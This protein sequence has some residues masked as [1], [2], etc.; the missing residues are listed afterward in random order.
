MRYRIRPATWAGLSGWADNSEN[1]WRD[2]ILWF[3]STLPS[4][5]T[6]VTTVNVPA[7]EE[8]EERLRLMLPELQGKQLLISASTQLVL[9]RMI[10]KN[11]QRLDLLWEQS[12][13]MPDEYGNPLRST[14]AD[15]RSTQYSLGS[16]L[17]GLNQAALDAGVPPSDLQNWVVAEYQSRTAI[18]ALPWTEIGIAVG[19]AIVA[20]V[21]IQ[22]FNKAQ[23]ISAVTLAAETFKDHPEVL[24]QVLAKITGTKTETNWGMWGLGI[25]VAAL[26]GTLL[27]AFLVGQV[28]KLAM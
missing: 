25:G 28:K 8:G 1:E 11:L 13:S 12:L 23:E 10:R 27:L 24:A 26:G 3:Q 18:A 17:F 15:Q 9:W 14:V 6:G 2:A 22:Y 5:M 19:I 20:Y 7:T 16:Q 4:W 21:V